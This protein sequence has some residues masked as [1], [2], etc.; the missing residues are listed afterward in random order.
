M[1]EADRTWVEKHNR[2]VKLSLGIF[3]ACLILAGG[4][5]YSLNFGETGKRLNQ[6]FLKTLI[7]RQLPES[8][9]KARLYGVLGD[10]HYAEN[11]YAATRDAYEQALAANFDQ[12]QILNNLAWLYAT[13]PDESL[14]NPQRALYLAE[15]AAARL[16]EAHV[17]DTLAQAF[18]VNEMHADAV[19]T[20]RQA[21]ESA[22]QK[23]R[24]YFQEQLEKF[25][26]A[27]REGE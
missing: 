18:H 3:F 20:A 10:L 13:C 5:C 27:A 15:S 25:E 23:D 6:R 19:R 21:L 1:C 12:P 16:K 22:G 17:L 11:N 7:Q 14:R 8:A 4:A 26:K 24:A 2:K 9:D